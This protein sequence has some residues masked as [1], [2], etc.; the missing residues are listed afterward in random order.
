MQQVKLHWQTVSPFNVAEHE[1][2]PPTSALHRFCSVAEATSSSQSQWILK[3]SLH[4]SKRSLQRGT[5]HQLGA[6]APV[7][8]P[9]GEGAT[10]EAPA[11][12]KNRPLSRTIVLDIETT[13]FKSRA[14]GNL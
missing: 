2:N 11:A 1:H 4:F 9:A 10:A 5:T 7:A 3:P 6:G 12:P 8:R 14:M 13:P